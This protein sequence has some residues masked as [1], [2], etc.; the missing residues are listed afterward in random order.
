MASSERRSQAPL[1]PRATTTVTEHRRERRDRVY[2]MTLDQFP[3]LEALSESL[4][5]RQVRRLS[6]EVCRSPADS[7]LPVQMETPPLTSWRWR[8]LLALALRL[9]DSI[10]VFRGWSTRQKLKSDKAA[11]PLVED[12]KLARKRA[13]IGVQRNFKRWLVHK[14]LKTRETHIYFLW[15]G[16]WKGANI[17]PGQ[18]VE[19]SGDFTAPN[20]WSEWKLMRWCRVLRAYVFELPYASPDGRGPGNYHFKFTV[21]GKETVD[22]Q[23]V[24]SEKKEGEICMSIWTVDGKRISRRVKR[25]YLE[26]I[27]VATRD[28]EGRECN[29]I[30][31]PERSSTAVALPPS[32]SAK[33]TLSTTLSMQSTRPSLTMQLTQPSLTEDNSLNYS[34]TA[35]VTLSKAAIAFYKAGHFSYRPLWEPPPPH[36]YE[37]IE[38]KFPELQICGVRN[39]GSMC[40]LSSFVQCLRLTDLSSSNVLH[41]KLEK[42]GGKKSQEA[43]NPNLL[44]AVKTLIAEFLI[45][46]R[47]YLD[48]SDMLKTLPVFYAIG[49]QQDATEAGRYIFEALGG[50]AKVPFSPF[51]GVFGGR[52]V[53][54]TKC[55]ECGRISE[56]PEKIYDLGLAVPTEKAYKKMS[57][58]GRKRLSVQK[59][60]EDCMRVEEMS[61]NNAYACSKCL[62]K[63]PATKWLEI[64]HPPKHLFL[65][66]NR[67]AWD[68]TDGRSKKQ[69]TPVFIDKTLVL[70]D[71]FLYDLYA[72]IIHTGPTSTSGH[73]YTIG[74]RSEGSAQRHNEWYCFDDSR[75][76]PVPHTVI[77]KIASST[78]K[79]DR[80]YVLFYRCRTA[81]VSPVPA[82]PRGLYDKARA[83]EEAAIKEMTEAGRQQHEKE[84]HDRTEEAKKLRLSQEQASDA[85]PSQ[86]LDNPHDIEDRVYE[87][88]IRQ[89]M[90]R[91]AMRRADVPHEGPLKG[92]VDFTINYMTRPGQ[93]LYIVG[94]IEELGEWDPARAAPMRWT[95]GHNWTC[96]LDLPQGPIEYKF[97]VKEGDGVEWEFGGNHKL[98]VLEEEDTEL[99]DWWGQG[100]G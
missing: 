54:K 96:C 56:R 25:H 79:D 15:R 60:L 89:A 33:S 29:V 69:K 42:K 57:E 7:G 97:L 92:S 78:E 87:A 84:K 45:T 71:G 63:Q 17:E 88:A 70:N 31:V 91:E 61:G 68:R 77:D 52:V 21:D 93:N 28:A 46:E 3:A 23:T 80:P 44:D 41:F 47:S 72:T 99:L 76:T 43:F 86:S 100:G 73:Y 14:P 62:K 36:E 16:A 95:P 90:R 22:R 8:P 51:R 59:L 55:K 4:S 32:Q 35:L 18:R 40:Y 5:K 30:S 1:A 75:V 6:L 82:I 20:V 12:I 67:F 13:A 74:R 49:R 37:C 34:S 64:L 9:M 24:G 66:L 2:N 85:E 98:D 27:R 50:H 83:K 58:K 94:S 26:T 81:S 65:C 38:A 39:H 48:P 11:A 53:T 10:A 19:I